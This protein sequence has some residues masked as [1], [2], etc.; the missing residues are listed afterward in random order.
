MKFHFWQFITNSDGVPIQ[1]ARIHIF[2]SDQTTKAIIEASPVSSGILID[3]DQSAYSYVGQTYTEIVSNYTTSDLITIESDSN[4]FFEFWVSDKGAEN[5]LTKGYDY[6]QLFTLAII[7]SGFIT[8]CIENINIFPINYSVTETDT[9]STFKNKSVSN[10]IIT[11]LDQHRTATYS[12]YPH[13]IYP[14]SEASLETEVDWLTKNKL[15]SNKHFI[16]LVNNTATVGS[17]NSK[18]VFLS[19]HIDENVSN[20]TEQTNRVTALSGEVIIINGDILDITNDIDNIESDIEWLSGYMSDNIPTLINDLNI[21]ESNIDNLNQDLNWLSGRIEEVNVGE[22]AE[23]VQDIQDLN[24]DILFLSGKISKN[25]FD[26]SENIYS[27][28]DFTELVLSIQSNVY[29][30]YN[31]IVDLI[32]KT[33]VITGDIISMDDDINNMEADI[34][35]L[36]SKTEIITGDIIN[37]DTLVFDNSLSTDNSYSGITTN[38]YVREAVSQ[39]DI[40]YYDSALSGYMLAQADNID[41]MLCDAMA[42]ESKSSNRLCNV[43][44]WGFVRHDVWNWDTTKKLLFVDSLSSGYMTTDAPSAAGEVSQAVASI[45]SVNIIK[46]DPQLAYTEF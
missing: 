41:T 37:I 34:A 23:V 40:L 35:T 17:Y 26:I 24:T 15:I 11:L 21:A 14:A 10:R 46:F 28:E 43:L 9:T 8:T 30:N 25:I 27:T 39:F 2:K 45:R 6:T 4:G 44:Q 16:D 12:S 1:D 31:N 38:D 33:N 18:I 3:I 13:D 19:G 20:L 7:K 29:I 36:L 22:I 32:S 5:T 42:L